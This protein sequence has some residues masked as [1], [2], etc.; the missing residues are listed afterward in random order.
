MLSINVRDE[1]LLKMFAL[2]VRVECSR[3]MFTN[4]Y[5]KW[6][7]SINVLDE[8]SQINVENESY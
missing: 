4:K 6:K 8:C 3:W 1:C 7:L 2:N 5:W